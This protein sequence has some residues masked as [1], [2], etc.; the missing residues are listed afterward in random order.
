MGLDAQISGQKVELLLRWR[1]IFGAGDDGVR[2]HLSGATRQ[3]EV[4][5]QA[6]RSD[7][8]EKCRQSNG[9][10]TA[11]FRRDPS[12]HFFV[13]RHGDRHGGLSCAL[14]FPGLSTPT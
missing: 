14:F 11:A 2:N 8:Q 12:A 4:G 6:R 5:E 13:R 3:N 7:R 10:E 1:E 9:A